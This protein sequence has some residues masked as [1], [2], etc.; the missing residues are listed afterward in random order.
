MLPVTETEPAWGVGV[1]DGDWAV[2]D[3]DRLRVREGNR[4]KRRD[5]RDGRGE[6]M[7][8]AEMQSTHRKAGKRRR[9]DGTPSVLPEIYLA[10]ITNLSR[11]SLCQ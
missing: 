4:C 8:F 2:V 6:G 1:S 7:A 10:A 9:V 5:Q 11:S 3:I